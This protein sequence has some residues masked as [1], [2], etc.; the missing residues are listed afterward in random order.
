MWTGL[1]GEMKWNALKECGTQKEKKKKSQEYAWV[2]CL[3]GTRFFTN[4]WPSFLL[5]LLLLLY[6]TEL[7]IR[8]ISGKIKREKCTNS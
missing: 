4:V 3:N 5:F 7:I 8:D 2:N 1:L 6:G